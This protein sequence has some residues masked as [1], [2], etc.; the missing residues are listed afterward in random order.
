MVSMS[1]TSNS[2]ALLA[3]TLIGDVM[4]KEELFMVI[5]LHD[6][7]ED[8]GISYEEIEKLFGVLVMNSVKLMTKVYQGVKTQI[9]SI[10][11]R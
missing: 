8:K 9:M 6:V 7:C 1:F 4:Y 5:F 3:R 10:M 11:L 2:Q